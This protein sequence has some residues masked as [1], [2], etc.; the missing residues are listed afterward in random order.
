MIRKKEREGGENEELNASFQTPPGRFDAES[1][2][3]I[4]SKGGRGRGRGSNRLAVVGGELTEAR[5][6]IRAITTPVPQLRLG[7]RA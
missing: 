7:A 4:V 2:R 3:V 6:R 1:I 5:A